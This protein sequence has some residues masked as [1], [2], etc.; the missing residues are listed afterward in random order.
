MKRSNIV[1]LRKNE[2][3]EIKQRVKLW[4]LNNYRDMDQRKGDKEEH[5]MKEKG[6]RDEIQ[7]E[8]E[9][10]V[11]YCD[12]IVYGIRDQRKGEVTR[13]KGEGKVMKY[14]KKEYT[15]QKKGYNTK[16]SKG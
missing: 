1:I 8:N 15:L 2:R 6:R 14:R 12:S 3:E 10:L 13:R 7:R 16:E 4:F 9:Y 5:N 11:K